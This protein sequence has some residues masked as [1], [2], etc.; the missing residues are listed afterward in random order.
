MIFSSLLANILFIDEIGATKVNKVGIYILKQVGPS[1]TNKLK[2]LSNI[3]RQAGSSVINRLKRLLNSFILIGEI[4]KTY[5]N[6]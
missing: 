1:T 3:L 6:L 2:R 4:N 5:K